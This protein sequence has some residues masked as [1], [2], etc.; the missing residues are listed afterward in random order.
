MT[1]GGHGTDA[2]S[3]RR[4]VPAAPALPDGKRFHV[5]ISYRSSNRA[6][7]LGLYDELRA[8]GNRVFLDAMELASSAPLASSLSEALQ[9]SAAAVFCFSAANAESAWC[10]K[11]YDTLEALEAEGA[12]F[13]YVAVR[14]DDAPPAAF[15]KS[16][17]YVDCSGA[18]AG[19]QAFDLLR[20]LYGLQGKAL[21]EECVKLEL[22]LGLTAKTKAAL[23]QVKAAQAAGAKDELLKLAASHGA[24]WETSPAL[25]AEVAESL[26]KLKANV[27]ALGVLERARKKFPEAVRLRQ[28]VGLAQARQGDTAAAQLTLG[29]LYREG[30]LDPETLGIYARTWNDVYEKSKGA[31]GTPNVWALLRSRDL[32]RQAFEAYPDDFYT[33]IN[34]ATKSLLL[35]EAETA[36]MISARVEKTV[37]ANPNRDDYWWCATLGELCLLQKR[38][39]DAAKEYAG[40]RA[41][42]PT[43]IGSAETTAK[44]A[45]R[46]LDALGAGP[47]DRA[48]VMKVF[49]DLKL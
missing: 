43:A 20:V 17:I 48:T 40:A 24:E 21:P 47:V 6:K 12:G 37:L 22:K 1:N 11:E 23:V 38:Y 36:G 5:F 15:V 49:G 9:E 16:R 3:W 39:A 13:R 7:V 45:V 29:A 46:I 14:L 19:P 25:H 33:G 27:E 30:C 10:R 28:L 18:P 44:Q 41:V 4:F 42:D 32:Y 8:A 31:G 2:D 34:A 35:G 26:I